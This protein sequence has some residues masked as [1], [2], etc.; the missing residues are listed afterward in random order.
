MTLIIKGKNARLQVVMQ[1]CGNTFSNSCSHRVASSVSTQ[2]CLEGT[3]SGTTSMKGPTTDTKSLL[4]QAHEQSNLA[5]AT[6]NFAEALDS[7]L[8]TSFPQPLYF[9]S[10]LGFCFLLSFIHSVLLKAAQVHL[11]WRVS[12]SLPR[13]MGSSELSQLPF[14]PLLSQPCLQSLLCVLHLAS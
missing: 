5:S 8:S 7:F 6:P 14:L 11:T 2:T 13:I 12:I 4:A 10:L 3:H 1:V 9:L